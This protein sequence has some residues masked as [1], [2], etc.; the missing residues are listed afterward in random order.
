MGDRQASPQGGKEAG[1]SGD[2]GRLR[3]AV[4]RIPGWPRALLGVAIV[5]M[6]AGLGLGAVTALGGSGEEAIPQT[7]PAAPRGAAVH[8]GLVGGLLPDDP[9]ATTE[10]AGDATAGS[11]PR[12]L[13][14]WSP[15][16][17][18]LGFSF[19]AGFCVAYALRSVLRLAIVFVG[20]VLLAIFG[21]QYAGLVDV[22]WARMGEGYESFVGWLGGQT[23]SFQRFI[24]G[25]L[26]S[27]ASG[28]AGLAMGFRVR[29]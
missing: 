22:N 10:P 26:P 24:T 11:A 14:V 19:F 21:L 2:A 28:V 5:L 25:Y 15:A 29:A 23:E 1:G 17:F 16:I 13:E 8:P 4:R 7:P 9:P 6:A 3:N 12:G 27:S 20:L 18:R